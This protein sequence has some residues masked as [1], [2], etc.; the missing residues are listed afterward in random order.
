ML[1]IPSGIFSKVK[2]K[3]EFKCGFETKGHDMLEMPSG[4]FSKLFLKYG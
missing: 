2:Y 1:E 3:L 4:I